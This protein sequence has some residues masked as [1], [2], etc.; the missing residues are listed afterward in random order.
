MTF[1]SCCPGNAVGCTKAV[2]SPGFRK[3][4]RT[5]R[6]K[7]AKHIPHGLIHPLCSAIM[8]HLTL[9]NSDGHGLGGKRGGIGIGRYEHFVFFTIAHND[10]LIEDRR[11]YVVNAQHTP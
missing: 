10:V 6:G 8:Y 9:F 5:E 4:S 1:A 2:P 7:A 3:P 11:G